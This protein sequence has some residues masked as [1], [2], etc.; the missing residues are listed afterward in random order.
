MGGMVSW[1]RVHL[2]TAG[3]RADARNARNARNRGY[4]ATKDQL[5]TRLKVPH[6]P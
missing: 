3:G 1:S 2:Q 4:T 6:A 5:L